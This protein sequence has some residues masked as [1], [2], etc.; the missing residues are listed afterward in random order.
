MNV[1]RENSDA[2]NAVLTVKINP[3]D[4]QN[5]VKA[6]LE[7]YRKTAKIPGFRPG[8]VPFSFVQK[9]YG[10]SVLAEELNKICSEALYNF[11]SENKLEVLGNPIP[12]ADY[13]V[14]GDFENPSDFEFAFEIGLSPFFDL[15]I[16]SR[17]N[18][19]YPIVKID[20]ALIDKQVED[21]RRRYGKLIS[22]SVVG[23]KD[24]VIG[25]FEEL[26]E[27][28]VI[29]ENGI[30]HSST[31]SL[32]FLDDKKICQ[33]F[34]GKEVNDCLEIDPSKVSKGD[35]DKASLL[36]IS[37][38]ELV[39]LTDRFKFTVTEIKKMEMADLDTE[40]FN[41]LFANGEVSSEEEL[42]NRVSSDLEKMFAGDSERILT[43]DVYNYLLKETNMN[44]PKDFLR[45]WIKLSSEKPVTDEEI[46]TEFE[47][48][49]KSLKWQLIQT[50]I[51][52]DNNIQVSQEDALNHTKGLLIGNYAQYGM[53]APDDAELVETAKR[54]LTN[55]E[56]A[57]TIYDQL[58]EKKLTD[59]FKS[60]VNLKT[61]EV[62]YDDFVAIASK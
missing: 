12:K 28:G 3:D 36:G 58:A 33:L 25:K 57:N 60:T 42:R 46:D 54:L 18:F 4:Y 43:R 23:E 7:K 44:F 59:Y 52:K 39:G 49:L 29:K 35:K 47:A 27:S 5:K 51:F 19:D 55:K 48:Y 10:K 24:M 1:F 16:S 26:N 62:S 50:R 31:I 14:V 34:I 8:N 21:L 17:T 9:Q 11:I 30:S 15:P 22:V 41:K 13:T 32:E 20:K 53:P 6:A 40:L 61:K 2:L 38:S 56:Q 37:E 45:R